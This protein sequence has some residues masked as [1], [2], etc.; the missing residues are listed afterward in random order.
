MPGR[1]Q[2]AAAAAGVAVKSEG[3]G[4]QGQGEDDEMAQM[5]GLM[6]EM[7]EVGGQRRILC[8]P[9]FHGPPATCRPCHEM[10]QRPR[11]GVTLQRYLALLL[12]RR[13]RRPESWRAASAGAALAAA[14]AGRTS[15]QA[16]C[17]APRRPP[18]SC[19]SLSRWWTSLPLTWRLYPSAWLRWARRLRCGWSARRPR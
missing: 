17:G 9:A 10:P 5:A 16:A 13:G 14:A 11:A 4:S 2:D 19:P 12:R 6:A 7:A 18:K 3:A 8:L 1:P 15:S